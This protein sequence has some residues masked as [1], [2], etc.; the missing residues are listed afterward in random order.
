MEYLCNNWHYFI[1]G[2]IMVFILPSSTFTNK[3]MAC[4]W[5][6]I[7]MWIAEKRAP[8]SWSQNE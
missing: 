4:V 2:M 1:C 5:L 8:S 3:I 7:S 6:G